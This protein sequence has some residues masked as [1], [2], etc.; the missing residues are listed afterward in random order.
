MAEVLHVWGIR[1][2]PEM[3]KLLQIFADFEVPHQFYDLRDFPPEDAQLLKWAE[4]LN[5]DYPNA[6]RSTL[7]KKSER[8]FLRLSEPER[9]NWIRKHYHVIERPVVEDETGAV[10]IIGA[11]PERIAKELCNIRF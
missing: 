7:W 11:R 1:N 10:L 4:F 6:G 8:M 3:E 2:E 9:L 5:Q